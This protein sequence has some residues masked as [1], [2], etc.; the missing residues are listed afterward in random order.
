MIKLQAA[1]INS[2]NEDRDGYSFKR[3]Q[4]SIVFFK[5]INLY[6]SEGVKFK[7]P[8]CFVKWHFIPKRILGSSFLFLKQLCGVCLH[9]VWLK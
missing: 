4:V 9:Y 6:K 3:L 8:S 1:K 7:L 2:T 5:L